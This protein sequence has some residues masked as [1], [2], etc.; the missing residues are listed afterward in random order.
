MLGTFAAELLKV[1]KRPAI[2][3]LVGVQALVVALL[4]YFFTYLFVVVLPSGPGMPEGLADEFVATLLPR[5]VA[6]SIVSNASGPVALIL[7]VLTA[8]SEYGWRTI[9]LMVTQRPRRL[10]LL[11]GKLGAVAAA[12]V[13][14]AVVTAVTAIGSSTLVGVL[15]GA[16][17]EMPPALDLLAAFGSAVLVLF[18]WATFGLGLAFIFRGTGLAI[19]LGLGWMFVVEGILAAIPLGGAVETVKRGLLSQNAS[20]LARSLGSTPEDVFSFGLV[21]IEPWSAVAVICAYVL[22]FAG[23]AIAVF[24]RREIT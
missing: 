23:V 14:L 12:C 18:A 15:E 17:L 8:G 16:S 11:L 4:G 21:E 6:G 20:A 22:V 19:G 3:I 7:G 13:V 24:T 9:R 2:A 1:R 10:T 5:A